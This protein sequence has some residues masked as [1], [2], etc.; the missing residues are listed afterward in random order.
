MI[1]WEGKPKDQNLPGEHL[2]NDIIRSLELD[3][4]SHQPDFISATYPIT[5]P[6]VTLP[7]L[8]THLFK[9][10]QAWRTGMEEKPKDHHLSPIRAGHSASL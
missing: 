3:L 8:L 6:A 2:L 7:S 9:H 1:T 5:N 10:R 4:I